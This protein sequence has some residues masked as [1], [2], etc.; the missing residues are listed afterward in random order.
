MDGDPGAVA[1]GGPGEAAAP[2]SRRGHGVS[3]DGGP[4]Q[5]HAAVASGGPGEVAAPDGRPGQGVS[6]DGGPGQGHGA[7]ADAGPGTGTEADAGQGRGTEADRA[8]FATLLFIIALFCQLYM[9]TTL[10]LHCVEN[11][12]RKGQR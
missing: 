3:P 10:L 8:M 9:F 6:P 4:G 12:Q 7:E 5:G 2:D 1:S 11:H